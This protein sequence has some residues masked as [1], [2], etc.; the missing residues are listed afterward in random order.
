[1]FASADRILTKAASLHTK[2]DALGKALRETLRMVRSKIRAKDRQFMRKMAAA[3]KRD[4]TLTD[5]DDGSGPGPSGSEADGVSAGMMSGSDMGL[6]DGHD[7]DAVW[8]EASEHA[9]TATSSTAGGGGGVHG[10]GSASS[11]AG[12]S[13]THSGSEVDDWADSPAAAIARAAGLRRPLEAV[14]AEASAGTTKD[15]SAP[16]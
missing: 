10:S 15:G 7:E 12:S 1:M 11:V 8:F 2:A 9:A 6:S 5:G 4:Q 13:A 3:L 16:A 14:V